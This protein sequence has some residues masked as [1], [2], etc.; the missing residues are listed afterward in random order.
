[1]YPVGGGNPAF[2]GYVIR[3]AYL[4][5]FEREKCVKE[6][7]HKTLC[8]LFAGTEGEEREKQY[9]RWLNLPCAEV[10]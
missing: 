9:I 2:S 5:C 6:F 1:M 10:E 7:L 4:R 8:L 3:S